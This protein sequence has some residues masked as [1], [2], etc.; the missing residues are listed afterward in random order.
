MN[1]RSLQTTIIFL[2]IGGILA[3]ALGGFFGSA[4][5]RFTSSLVRFQSSI[6][7]TFTGFQEF[8]NAPN[9][10]ATLRAK[11]QRLEQEVSSLQ[12]KVI[13]LQQ[14]AN[15]YDTLAALVD[16]ARSNPENRNIKANVI[17]EDESPFLHYLIVDRGSNDGLRRGMPVVT[18]QGLV[19][20][21][22]AVIADAARVQLITDPASVVNVTLQNAQADALLLGSITGDISLD[23]IPQD[24]KPQPGDLII[25]SGLGGGYPADLI[26]GQIVTFRSTPNELY[27]K[28]TVQSAVDFRRLRMVLVITN[29]RPVDTT[30]LEP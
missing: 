20:R 2:V 23:A 6:S 29:F 14:K 27:N 5:T 9:D 8:I 13:E 19:G 3:L 11:N 4:S 28:A 17:G 10:I 24:V 26:V 16:Y 21:I 15:E 22:D 18:N 7:K 30:P 1:A 25:T 12:S